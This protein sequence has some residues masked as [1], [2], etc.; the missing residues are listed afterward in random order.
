MFNTILIANRGAIATR[1]IRT[2]KQLGIQSIAVYHQAD[3]DSLHVQQADIA[4][5]LGEGSVA[6]T[7]LNIDAIIKIAKQ[8]NA[9]AIHPGYGFL[10]ENTLFVSACENNDLVFIGPTTAQMEL[11]G[12]KHLAREAAEQAGVPLVP[13]TP[14]LTEKQ[15]AITWANKIGYPIMLKS[16]AG[17]GGIGM[18]ACHTDDDLNNAWDSVKRLGASYFSNDGV[19]LEKLIQHARH[20]EVQIFADGKGNAVS[21]GE[22]DCSAQ[23]RNQKVVEETPAHNISEDIREKLHTTAEQL[24][25]SVQ[26]RNAGTVEF[27]YDD[28]ASQNKCGVSI[29]LNAWSSKPQVNW[30]TYMTL[31]TH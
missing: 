11:F 22:R 20:I 13:G 27:I 10:S 7:Y 23:R 29:L 16:T 5:C 25:A 28:T 19:F 9:Q 12:L 1:I 6:D 18:Q 15:D 24:M 31:K 3:K 14:L 17:G 8:H 21:F 2:L 30:E 26:Y 4:V